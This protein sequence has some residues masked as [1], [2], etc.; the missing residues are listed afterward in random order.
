[1]IL[2]L[3][4]AFPFALGIAL[5]AVELLWNRNDLDVEDRPGWMDS[6]LPDGRLEKSAKKFIFIV[7]FCIVIFLCYI[8]NSI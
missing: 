4:L 2:I 6:W 5:V 8:I 3:F 7:V 1:M